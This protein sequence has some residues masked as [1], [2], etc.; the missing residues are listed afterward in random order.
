MRWPILFQLRPLDIG[1][2]DVRRIAFI[3]GILLV[4]ALG[5]LTALVFQKQEVGPRGE[6]GEPG[7]PGPSG[8]QG[9]VGPAGQAGVDTSSIRFIDGECRQPCLLSCEIGE[10]IL[11][12][13][14]IN[15]GGTLV[16]EDE[17]RA[18]FRPAQRT[19]VKVVIACVPK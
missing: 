16:F 13:H 2:A 7:L 14:A 8:A 6:R 17:T 11:T 15:P 4:V 12:I 5:L 18:T 1:P 3:L 19:A 9:V 10:R